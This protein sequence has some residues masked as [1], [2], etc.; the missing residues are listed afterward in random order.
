MTNVDKAQVEKLGSS[1]LP[2]FEELMGNLPDTNEFGFNE[3][4]KLAKKTAIFPGSGTVGAP[5][6]LALGLCGEA[7]EVAE[8]IKKY[9]RDGIKGDPEEWREDLVKEMGDVLWYLANLAEVF[10][11]DFSDAAITNIEKLASR[12]QRGVLGGSGDNR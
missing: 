9:F 12:Q 5:M 2:K 10:E 6:Y 11:V 7:G 4:Q 1:K 8:K 3:Y